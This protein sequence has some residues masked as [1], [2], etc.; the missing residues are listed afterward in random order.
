MTSSSQNLDTET[1]RWLAAHVD[2][3]TTH[4]HLE[5]LRPRVEA[6]LRSRESLRTLSLEGVEPALFPASVLGQ[7]HGA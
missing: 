6:Y 4:A 5:E 3:R 7:R 1:F 2:L